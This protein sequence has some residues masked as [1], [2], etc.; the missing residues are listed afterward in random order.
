[1]RVVPHVEREEFVNAGAIVFCPALDFLAACIELDESRLRAIAP[2]VDVPLV[3]RHLDAIPRVCEGGAAAGPI[4]HLTQ[5][6]RWRWLVSTRSTI[7]QTSAPHVGLASSPQAA[8]A[9][10]VATVVR[11]SAR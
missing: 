3:R 6:E 4:G 1:V 9:R 10:L 7:I 8:L 2:D 11:V 5:R